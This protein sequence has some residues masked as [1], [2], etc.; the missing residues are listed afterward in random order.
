MKRLV[1]SVLI[2]L[3]VCAVFCAVFFLYIAPIFAILRCGFFTNDVPL[4][5]AS[6]FSGDFAP[7]SWQIVLIFAVQFA[8]LFL[9]DFFCYRFFSKVLK[10]Y[11]SNDGYFRSFYS[12]IL[13]MAFFF[14]PI[15]GLLNIFFR[16]PVVLIFAILSVFVLFFTVF[17]SIMAFKLLSDFSAVRRRELFFRG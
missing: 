15:F 4:A 9:A 10:I 8:L 16:L 11:L 17:A 13:A 14:L 3:L 12:V 5:T 1:V 7:I 6:F 2:A